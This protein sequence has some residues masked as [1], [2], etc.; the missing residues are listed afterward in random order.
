MHEVDP[1][2]PFFGKPLQGPNQWPEGLPGFREAVTAYQSAMTDFAR[3]FTRA[4]RARPRVCRRRT[5]IPTSSAPLRGFACST[6]PRNLAG[7]RTTSTGRRRIPTTDSSPF[8]SRTST[9]A[10]KCARGT[11][12]GSR[13][14][15][16]RATFVVNRRR[17][18]SRSG[19]TTDGPRP[20]TGSENRPGKDPLT[21]S[22]SSGTWTWRARSA[23][24]RPAADRN[25]PP[26]PRAHTL[27]QLRPAEA[28]AQLRLPPA[29]RLNRAPP[30]VGSERD[31]ATRGVRVRLHVRDAKPHP[32]PISAPA[33]FVQSSTA[34]PGTRLNSS[35]LDVTTVRP[36]DRACP[37]II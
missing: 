26:R 27:R 18:C 10:S 19:R 9:T 32:D 5:S 21:R 33:A 30:K 4:A 8:S 22:R 34:I 14:R 31:L 15:R 35:V 12:S 29:L 2:D 36:R 11:G 23:A 1:E 37:A 25:N 7:P 13:L 17:P 28:R 20:R 24:C 3:R 16:S 6:I